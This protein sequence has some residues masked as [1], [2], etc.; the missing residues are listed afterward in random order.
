MPD[1][2]NVSG[3]PERVNA[4]PDQTTMR[5]KSLLQAAILVCL[6]RGAAAGQTIPSP[7]RFW[8][9]RQE[10]SPFVGWIS[11]GAGR[12]GYGPRSGPLLGARYGI[13]FGGPVSLE[14]VV[15]WIPTT[16]D[17]IDP[18][19]AVG[20]RKVG[21]ATSTLLGSDLRVKLSI[22]GQRTW[23]HLNPFALA[24]IGLMWDLAGQ[25]GVESDLEGNDR[26]KFGTAFVGQLG[27]GLRIFAND[28]WIARTDALLHIWKLDTPTGF[29]DQ[30][31]GFTDIGPGEWVN[32]SSISLG[33]GYRF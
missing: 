7:Y 18:R 22:T 11:T 5:A 26:F 4:D 27:G 6:C 1:P 29:R 33:V 32:A 23:H 2:E 20:S 13:D 30:S 28:H 17:V 31:R 12:F 16:R 21:E 24:G 9:T 8:D 10:G 25:S 19:R 15:N 3:E 14:G